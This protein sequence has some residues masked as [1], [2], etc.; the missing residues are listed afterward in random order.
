MGRIFILYTIV[1]SIFTIGNGEKCEGI[2]INGKLYNK[3]ILAKNIDRPYQL[4]YDKHRNRVYFSYNVGK[5]EEDR[6]N[7]AYIEKGQPE[8]K[9]KE[10]IEDGFAIAIDNKNQKM[11]FG[12]SLG[13]YEESMKEGNETKKIIE[14]FN[15]WD[16]FFKEKLYFISYPQ[17]RLYKCEHEKSELKAVRQKH[18]HEKIFQHAIDGDG[19]S[20]ITN[21]TGLYMI[22]NGTTDRILLKGSKNFRCIEINNEGVA[23]FCGQHGIYIADKEHYTLEKIA[24]I[25]NIFGLTFDDGNNIIFSTPHEIVKVL[26]ENC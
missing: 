7:I 18:I 20:Y 23:F 10:N 21:K 2:H 4:C 12:G 14:G 1:A 22:K 17:Q 9:I 16:M 24:E 19:D 15:I 5:D 13:I 26:P 8:H 25:K 11:Y 6:F 3:E